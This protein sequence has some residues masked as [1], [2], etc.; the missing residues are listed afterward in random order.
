MPEGEMCPINNIKI[1][2]IDG[3]FK[4]SN[5]L[6]INST[7]EWQYLKYT[8]SHAIGI[9]TIAE[10]HPIESIAISEMKPCIDKN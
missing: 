9:S 4:I 3:S 6:N 1:V 2:K 10:R 8:D 7:D 5:S